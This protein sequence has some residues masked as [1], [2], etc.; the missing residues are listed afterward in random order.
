[1][2]KENNFFI[3]LDTEILRSV[4]FFEKNHSLSEEDVQ[5]TNWN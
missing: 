1:M 5:G 4:A 2:A 3:S